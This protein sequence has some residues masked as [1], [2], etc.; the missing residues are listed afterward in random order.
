MTKE[1][2]QATKSVPD[3]PKQEVPEVKKVEK[4]KYDKYAQLKFIEFSGAKLK[5]ETKKEID[6]LEAELLACDGAKPKLTQRAAICN[7]Q[8]LLIEGIPLPSCYKEIIKE[9]SNPSYYI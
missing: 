6:E 2:K 1:A 7:E 4:A 9:S 5:A 8:I 3:V